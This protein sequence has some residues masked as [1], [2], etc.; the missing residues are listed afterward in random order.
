MFRPIRL[1]SSPW[2]ATQPHCAFITTNRDEHFQRVRLKTVTTKNKIIR[3]APVHQCVC[4]PSTTCSC[5]R[6]HRSVPILAVTLQTFSCI[7]PI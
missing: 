1:Q 2:R 7:N 4:V 5:G 6:K 3:N